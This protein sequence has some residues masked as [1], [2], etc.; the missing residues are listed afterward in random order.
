MQK[1]HDGIANIWRK[2]SKNEK[3]FFAIYAFL[4]IVSGVLL[5]PK[6][7]MQQSNQSTTETSNVQTRQYISAIIDLNKA[8][9]EEL[10]TLPGIGPSKARVI[11]EYREKTP[12]TKPE[13]IM[14]V[15]GIGQKTYEK[16]KSRI[17]VDGKESGAQVITANIAGN[18]GNVGNTN[19]SNTS[20]NTANT[21][22]EKININ[23]ADSE[24]L[25]EL[26]NIGP[27][28]AQAIIDYRNQNGG[29]KS[30]DEIK[31]V[32]GI[33]DKTFEALKDLICIN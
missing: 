6:F 24:K 14:N 31:N 21:K 2:F 33:G 13:D 28:K 19:N 16:M 1:I 3:T 32:K 26:P 12:F 5:Q 10:E 23:T 18:P 25:Q 22:S 29:F 30:I 11:V 8:T 4:I 17:K 15:P 27:A 20:M 7:Y 9:T